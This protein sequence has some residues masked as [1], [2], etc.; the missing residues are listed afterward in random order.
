MRRPIAAVTLLALMALAGTAG[1]FTL[2]EWERYGYAVTIYDARTLA[3]GGAGLAAAE[4]A[5]GLVVNPALLGKTEG[6]DVAFTGAVVLAEEA[7]ETPLHDSFDGVIGYN[8]YALN[9]EV[10]D[11]FVGVVAFDPSSEFSEFDWAPVVA[12]G[13][14]PR[15]DMSYGCHIQYRDPDFQT[16]PADKILYDYYLEGDGGVNAFTVGLGQEV[17]PDVYV[18]LGVDFLRGDYKTSERTVYPPDSDE[19]DVST[20][21]EYE[22]VAGTR[23]TLGLQYEAFHRI[24]MALVYRTPFTLDGSFSSSDGGRSSEDFEYKYPGTLALGVKYRPRNLLTTVVTADIEFTNWSD[25]DDTMD[26]DP[27]L[28]DTVVYRLGVEHGFF[29]DTFA[30]FGFAYV[31]SYVDNSTTTA[32]FSLGLGMELMGVRVDLGGQVGIREYGMGD[33][34]RVRETTTLAMVTVTHAF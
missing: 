21:T 9:N 12:I 25:L 7:R 14:G 1:A 27:G 4:G 6:L 18:G 33:V 11:R 13:Y 23:F 8:T 24:D 32:A 3:M 22:N 10:Y 34:D 16:E 19:E 20:S 29:D 17:A 28:D 5:I 31:P 15:L 30:R 2:P 26:G